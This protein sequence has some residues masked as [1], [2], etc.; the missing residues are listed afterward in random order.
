MGVQ[1]ATLSMSSN[2]SSGL[3]ACLPIPSVRDFV[4]GDWESARSA[5]RAGVR[6][7]F[8]QPWFPQVEADFQPGEVWLGIAN[9]CLLVW[10]SLRD[11][12]PANRAT[13][14]NE[15][16]WM[17]GDVIELFFQAGGRRGYHEFHVT[18][19]NQR[20]QLFFPSA[21]S[22]AERR[23]HRHWAIAESRFESLA[24]IDADGGGW[25][26]LMAVPLDLVLDRPREDGCRRF[27]FSFSRYDYQPGRA[28]PVT[29]STSP[30]DRAD[31]HH[32][33]GWLDAVA[34]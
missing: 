13:T 3:V 2:V 17:T 25:E 27:K 8:G 5:L 11:A 18:P 31:F 9:E 23:G 16:T 1:I 12:Q 32:I 4:W 6:L 7:E 29:S 30:L 14:W 26:A 22:F 20:L 33:P 34:S 15:A 21:E 24:R 19:E 10:A 28:R